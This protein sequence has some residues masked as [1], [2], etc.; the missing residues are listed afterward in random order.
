MAKKKVKSILDKCPIK[1]GR[2]SSEERKKMI[3]EAAAP[4]FAEYGFA[5]TTTKQIAKTAG[6]SEGL[7][8][9]YFP[10]KE[11]LYQEMQNCIT[12][13]K[14][15]L[16]EVMMGMPNNSDTLILFIYFFYEILV[17]KKHQ[18]SEQQEIVTRLM[19]HSLLEDGHYVEGFFKDRV[20]V[21][22]DK[23]YVCFDK[24]VE[25]GEIIEDFIPPNPA[26]WFGHYI[27][28]SLSFIQL[29][30]K[31]LNDHKCTKEEFLSYIFHYALRGM[32]Y[33]DEVIKE[34]AKPGKLAAKI[35]ELRTGQLISK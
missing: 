11:I 29:P 20:N 13:G 2:V 25:D 19:L 32:G 24:A 34:K 3:V 23:L 27:N 30:D 31:P 33:K 22:M 28:L 18:H 35:E 1:C 26:L 12:T 21:V 10:S 17:L 14:Q 5:G 9:K 15:A 16:M 7:I 6:V 4:L 8:F